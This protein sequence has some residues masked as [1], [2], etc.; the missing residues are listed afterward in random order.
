LRINFVTQTFLDILSHKQAIKK[1][2]QGWALGFTIKLELE[3]VRDLCTNR[4]HS[5]RA[6]IFFCG[7]SSLAI[8]VFTKDMVV[9]NA[10]A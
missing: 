5:W 6:V 10:C 1:A 8:I 9:C 3:V 2:Q 4:V 7:N